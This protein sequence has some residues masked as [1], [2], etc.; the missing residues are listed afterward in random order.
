MGYTHYWKR[1]KEISTKKMTAILSDFK[2]VFPHLNANIDF[3]GQ[4]GFGDP[5]MTI[6]EVSFNGRSDCGHKKYEFDV[7]W[8]VKNALKFAQQ[9]KQN[10]QVQSW[11]DGAELEKR[12]CCGDCSHEPFIFNRVYK[13]ETWEK[14]KEGKYFSCCKTAFKPY[15]LAVITFLIIAKKHLGCAIDVSSDGQDYHWFDAKL[16]CQ[17]VLGYGLDFNVDEGVFANVRMA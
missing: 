9:Y 12:M 7:V 13:P 11:L 2:K 4:G 16:I 14:S 3:V 8:P 6:D 5:T 10:E 17:M 1:E 15:D